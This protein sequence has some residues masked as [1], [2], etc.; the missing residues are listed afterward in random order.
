MQQQ[1][2]QVTYSQPSVK[3][4]RRGAGAGERESAF[5]AP[6]SVQAVVPVTSQG[7]Q[8]WYLCWLKSFD[9]TGGI[10]LFSPAKIGFVLH[11]PYKIRDFF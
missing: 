6:F 8:G 9:Q 10:D 7:E 11:Y 3:K 5:S 2:Q 4:S 1:Q